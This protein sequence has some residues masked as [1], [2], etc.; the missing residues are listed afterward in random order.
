MKLREWEEAQELIGVVGKISE[1][2]A[3]LFEGDFKTSRAIANESLAAEMEEAGNRAEASRLRE[4]AQNLWSDAIDRMEG[5]LQVNPLSASTHIALAQAC[6]KLGRYE[7]ALEYAQKAVQQDRYDLR[8]N[9]LL[10]GQLH[11]R[12]VRAGIENLTEERAIEMVRLLDKIAQINPRHESLLK[13]RVVYY[14]KLLAFQM[15]NF[16][17]REQGLTVEARAEIAANFTKIHAMTVKSCREL[18]K[19]NPADEVNWRA[20]ADVIYQ[21]AQIVSEDTRKQQL[22]D[23]VEGVYQE[24]LAKNPDSQML[25]HAYQRYLEEIGRSGDVE[26]MLL[27]EYKNQS[28]EQKQQARLKLAK[29]YY[30]HSFFEKSEM[31]LQEVLEQEPG[32]YQAVGILAEVYAKTGNMEKSIELLSRYRTEYE[33]VEMLAWRE[34]E[35]LLQLKRL[36]PAEQLL[37]EIE[38]KYPDN[39]YSLLLRSQLERLRTN[40]VKAVEYADQLLEREPENINAFLAK[41]EALYFDKKLTEA[42][43]CLKQLRA[44]LPVGSNRGRNMLSLVYWSQGNRDAALAE[45]E[46]GLKADP[47]A[48][49]I[50]KRLIQLLWTDKRMDELERIYT[51]TIALY[52]NDVRVYIEAAEALARQADEQRKKGLSR[53]ALSLYQKAV[54]HMSKALQLSNEQQNKDLQR[55][56]TSFIDI[57]MRAG[58]KQQYERALSLAN[59]GLKINPKDI[60]MM[61]KKSEALYSLARKTEALSI[62]EQ[63]LAL[64]G[65]D[66]SASAFVLS[67]AEKVAD[68]AQLVSWCSQKLADRPDWVIMRLVLANLY[69]SQGERQKQIDEL[70]LAREKAP[71]KYFYAIDQQLAVAYELTGQQNKS[72]SCYRQLLEKTPD[73]SQ[74]L[75]NLA[76]TLFRLGGH[77]EEAVEL[78]QKAY[79]LAND[80]PDIMDTYVLVL[81]SN[82]DYDRAVL[83]A[84][85]AIQELQRQGKEAR[86][87]FSLRLGQGLAGQGQETKSMECYQ[88]ALRQVSLGHFN[89]DETSLR[90]QIMAAIELLNMEQQ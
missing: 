33:L 24:A 12:N 30:E 45:L 42:E 40:Y 63:A 66:V 50:R 79:Q 2:E 25:T 11:Y 39:K 87:E 48:V 47:G 76:Y 73:N 16:K 57:L 85:Q 37:G 4:E 90:K 15:A 67:R 3:Q 61:V 77:E 80:E 83:V 18:I 60:I 19:K 58:G 69:M 52:P 64:A 71:E 20:L 8:A 84:R 1:S 72:I 46:A 10:A 29:L 88:E 53:K 51:D 68:P 89:E 14:P 13:F 5:Y 7:K 59:Q 22:Y 41:A 34:I 6:F 82:K 9:L 23:E 38:A 27:D 75:N 74:M 78:A 54:G 28:G 31:Y 65:E 36:E 35:M 32:S 49:E 62:Y 21:Y 44:N 55:V 86:A 70:L 17:N 26:Q 43:N 81:L 56:V